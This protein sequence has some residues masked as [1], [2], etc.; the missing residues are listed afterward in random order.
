VFIIVSV[1][2]GKLVEIGVIKALT[3]SKS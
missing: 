2:I 3:K 1:L